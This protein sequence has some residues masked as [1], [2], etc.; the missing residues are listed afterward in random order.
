MMQLD[1]LVLYNERG[2]QRIIRFRTGRLNVITGESGTGKSSIIAILRFLLGGDSPHAPL[3][4]ISQTVKWYGL[5]A[6]IDETSFFI[7]RPAP[8]H[9]ATTTKAFLSIGENGIPESSNFEINATMNDLREYFGSLLGIADNLSIPADGQTR[10]PLS[11]NFRHALYFCFQG[12]GEI[13]NPDILFHRQ[14]HDFIPQTI[15]DTLPYFLGAQDLAALRK[16]EVLTQLRREIR[17]AS[18]KLSAVQELQEFGLGRAA[19]L[20]SE[21]RAAG[22]LTTNDI[23]TIANDAVAQLRDIQSTKAIPLDDNDEPSSEL[24]RLI[25]QRQILREN[26][27]SI[28]SDIRGLEDFAGVGNDYD[29]ELNEHRV[30]LASIGL[31]SE[32]RVEDATCPLCGNDIEHGSSHN[33]I[34]SKLGQVEHRLALARRDQPRIA[35]ARSA[36]EVDLRAARSKLADTELSLNSLTESEDIRERAN[37]TWQQSSFV[38]GRIAQFLDSTSLTSGDD[39]MHLTAELERLNEAARGLAEELDLETLRS[40]VTSLLA[41]IGH[42]MSEWARELGLEH[43]EYGARI[44]PHRLTVVADTIQGPAFMD[45]GEIGS[46]MNW[47]GYHLVSYLALQAFFIEHNRPV[48]S[49]VVIDQPSQAF[50]PMEHA[51]GVD[52]DELSDNDREHTRK[53]YKL[54]YDVTQRLDGKLQV[55]AFDHAD[56]PDQWFQDSIIE[57][58]REGNA[59]IPR[60]WL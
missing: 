47:V 15:R 7:A 38:R 14:N 50:F 55:I 16:R 8:A 36:L 37:A 40:R 41:I 20:I 33:E 31:I 5:L 32:A 39:L 42:K 24:D 35:Q 26:L 60:S 48:P 34:E 2:D 17:Q 19:A 1:A 22:L 58:W 18:I 56:F 21:A 51:G 13:A 45:S 27:R 46:G 52:F 53:L 4:P 30:R 54:M 23:P 11:A 28:S 29:S 3:G 49:F 12:Q 43:S 57:S 59:L 9:G 6:H 25:V 10:L 44:D